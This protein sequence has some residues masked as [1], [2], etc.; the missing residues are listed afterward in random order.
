MRS[1]RP[2]KSVR[3]SRMMVFQCSSIARTLM[4]ASCL[5]RNTI[6]PSRALSLTHKVITDCR[7]ISVLFRK[8]RWNK[9][10]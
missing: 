1:K 4:S 10:I 5:R 9:L 8:S 7:R 3:K 6:N 2:S